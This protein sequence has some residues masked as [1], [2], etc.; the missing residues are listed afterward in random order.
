MGLLSTPPLIR[1]YTHTFLN[2]K[3]AP[4]KYKI[5]THHAP[6]KTRIHIPFFACMITLNQSVN[7]ML[8]ITVAC[9]F[10]TPNL[11]CT[12]V[13]K[14]QALNLTQFLKALALNLVLF[15]KAQALNLAPFLKAQDLNLALFSKTQALNLAP[16][17]KPRL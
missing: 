4:H 2:S 3:T 15:L 10:S 1:I 13:L 7:S 12:S 16:Y 11:V 5:K 6:S 9:Y 8:R 17:P 14:A